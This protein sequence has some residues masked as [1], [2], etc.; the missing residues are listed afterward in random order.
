MGGQHHNLAPV[1]LGTNGTI[2]IGAGWV[3]G[4]VW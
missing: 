3:P 1:L 4:P 2:F